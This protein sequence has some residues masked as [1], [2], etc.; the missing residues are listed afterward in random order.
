MLKFNGYHCPKCG[1]KVQDHGHYFQCR[2]GWSYTP[3]EPAWYRRFLY[4]HRY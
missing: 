4:G 1:K 2:C 3:L